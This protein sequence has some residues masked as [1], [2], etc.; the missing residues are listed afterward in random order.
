MSQFTVEQARKIAAER[1]HEAY[2]AEQA[3]SLL[4][5]FD[6]NPEFDNFPPQVKAEG[7]SVVVTL[8]NRQARSL[9]KALGIR[10]DLEDK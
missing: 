4:T 9:R 7:T 5:Y 1:G 6:E 3:L 8:T 2:A 10:V